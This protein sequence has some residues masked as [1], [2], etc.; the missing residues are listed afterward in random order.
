MDEKGK[1]VRAETQ[2]AQ[3]CF[4]CGVAALN[5]SEH[6]IGKIGMECLRRFVTPLRSLR[7][8]AIQPYATSPMPSS[9]SLR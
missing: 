5:T 3:R 6:G 4:G 2:R 9:P 1:G 8:C 7:L